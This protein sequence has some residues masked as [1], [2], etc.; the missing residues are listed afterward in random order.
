MINLFKRFRKQNNTTNAEE[1]VNFDQ[2]IFDTLIE[3]LSKMRELNEERISTIIEHIKELSSDNT[4]FYIDISTKCYPMHPWYEY[5]ITYW[6]G[7][8]DFIIPYFLTY[9]KS[10]NNFVF[11]PFDATDDENTS[12][13]YYALFGARANE[14]CSNYKI[15]NDVLNSI[16][17][18]TL[19]TLQE[20]LPDFKIDD[21]YISN[22]ESVYSTD[23]Y[24]RDC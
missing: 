12:I 14:T 10:I 20:N 23:Y 7:H 5:Q 17:P 3:N 19:S 9:V 8:T 21:V 18:K 4:P 16:V 24:I 2:F 15:L 11:T 1:L 13:F 6:S 22:Y